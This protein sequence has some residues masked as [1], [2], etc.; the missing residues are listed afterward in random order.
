MTIGTVLLAALLVVAVGGSALAALFGTQLRASDAAGNGLAM[1][2]FAI[3]VL[4]GW[5][6]TAIVVLVAPFLAPHARH[7][8]DVP[9]RAL[10]LGVGG[11][12]VAAGVALVP[13]IGLLARGEV[14]TACRAMLLVLVAAVPFAVALH[15]AWRLFAWSLPDAVAMHAVLGMVAAGAVAPWLAK[16]L[17]PRREV[18][19]VHR[20][21]HPVLVFT[22]ANT[23]HVVRSADELVDALPAAASLVDARCQPWTVTA[24]GLVVAAPLPFATVVA[25]LLA[26]PRLHDDAQRD[27]EARRLIP[28]Q[29]DVTALSFV[30][31]G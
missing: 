18:P 2:W 12:F 4:I 31:P 7:P 24:N 1:A 29:R 11:A 25:R 30:L 15:A 22:A 16:A 21:V 10:A 14:P 19:A 9:W 17:A 3:A 26:M 5:G 27:A 8:A 13:T 20:V 23:V 28:M 6:A